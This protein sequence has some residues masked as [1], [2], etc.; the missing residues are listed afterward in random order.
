VG[1]AGGAAGGSAGAG[2]AGGAAATCELETLTVAEVDVQSARP[3]QGTGTIAIIAGPDGKPWFTFPGEVPGT[4]L[5]V[6]GRA[7]AQGAYTLFAVD[8]DYVGG[9]TLGSDGNV[10][11][12]GIFGGMHQ[13]VALSAG[14][15]GVNTF[16]VADGGGPIAQGPDGYLWF[17]GDAKGVYRMLPSTGAVTAVDLPI[18]QSPQSIAAGPD[19]NVWITD[20]SVIVSVTPAGVAT[21]LTPPGTTASGHCI[22]IIT[23]GPDG[24]MWFTEPDCEQGTNNLIGRVTP[25]GTF[26]EFPGCS[27]EPYE[28]AAGPDG[29]LWYGTPG[30]VGRITPAG[31]ATQFSGTRPVQGIAAVGQDLWFAEVNSF[32]QD[33]VFGKVTLP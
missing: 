22:G 29:N 33:G 16:D 12:N 11:L 31:V 5:S 24:N 1:G 10:W 23:A 15:G 17:G 14:G 25:A 4:S 27:D 26:T 9:M 2:G 8:L 21:V 3:L 7:E 28:I 18:P 6:V 30:Y 20:G 32:L 19:G 13:I